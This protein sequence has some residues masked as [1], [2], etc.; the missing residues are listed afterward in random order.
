MK[1]NGTPEFAENQFAT[2]QGDVVVQLFSCPVA[3]AVPL[4]LWHD[5]QGFGMPETSVSSGEMNRN[6]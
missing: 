2:R 1:A 4:S 3:Q 5:V 6:V